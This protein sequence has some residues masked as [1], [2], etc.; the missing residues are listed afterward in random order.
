RRSVMS[1]FS[2][3]T[4][5]GF[6]WYFVG[7]LRYRNIC[8]AGPPVKSSPA[9]QVVVGSGR[10]GPDDVQAA[11]VWQLLRRGRQL[12]RKR[13]GFGA[14]VGPEADPGVSAARLRHV[15]RPV[16]EL[17][18][19]HP[20]HGPWSRREERKGRKSDGRGLRQRTIPVEHEGTLRDRAAQPLGELRGILAVAG[21]RDGQ[22]LLAAPAQ[23]VVRGAEDALQPLAHLLKHAVARGMAPL[24]VDGLE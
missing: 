23:D 6:P 16:G 3:R 4:S 8:R 2:A 18:D 24:V 11:V 17:D 7:I 1:A 13:L 19:L 14:G 20:G 10:V 22:E 12:L 9:R 15:E 5:S 21:A